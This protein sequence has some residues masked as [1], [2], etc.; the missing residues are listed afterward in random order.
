MTNPPPLPPMHPFLEALVRKLGANAFQR[1]H[2]V[3]VVLAILAACLFVYIVFASSSAAAERERLQT[4]LSASANQIQT[5]ETTLA[6]RS[7]ADQRTA[8]QLA[9]AKI[10]IKNL[11]QG[12]AG[13]ITVERKRLERQFKQQLA[14]QRA[15][16]DAARAQ[17]PVSEP[18]PI[19]LPD[20][21]AGMTL[22]VDPSVTPEEQ[23]RQRCLDSVQ[24][25]FDGA[26]VNQT[27]GGMVSPLPWIPGSPYWFWNVNMR[28]SGTEHVEPFKCRS[29]RDQNFKLLEGW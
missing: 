15:S 17:I 27:S 12:Q 26:P 29:S 3:S 8:Q 1:K 6:E 10:Q 19:E 16:L 18:A 13:L 2:F 24:A 28:G 4:Q 23:F 14:Q 9:D 5:L 22:A 20:S 21:N 11:Q 7:T 25:Y